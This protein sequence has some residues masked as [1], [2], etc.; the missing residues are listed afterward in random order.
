MSTMRTATVSPDRGT[1][2]GGL[3][4]RNDNNL[5]A[6][7]RS[8]LFNEYNVATVQN[9]G[10]SALNGGGGP[11]DSIPGIGIA[12]GVINDSSDYYG[13]VPAV[14]LNFTGAPSYDDV[15]ADINNTSKFTEGG[16][17]SSPWIPNLSSP[18]PGSV[19]PGDQPAYTGN[20]PARGVEYGT[21][22]G[23]ELSPNQ[24][25]TSIAGQKLG[26]YISGKSYLDSIGAYSG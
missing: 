1:R 2:D 16:R 20:L 8:P 14:D 17:P 18:G 23:S 11:G 25:T 3:G 12:N 9:A 13:I 5:K 15:Q 26:A 21:G 24:S 6:M 19:F 22:L 4:R 7:F 10:I